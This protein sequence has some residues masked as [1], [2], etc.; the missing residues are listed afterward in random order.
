MARQEKPGRKDEALQVPVVGIGAS[1]GG[2]QSLEAVFDSLPANTGMA[3][4]V[5]QHLSPDFKSL[6]DEILAR[7]TDMPISIAKEDML[8]EADHIYLIPPKK[9]LRIVDY[10]FRLTEFP[11]GIHRPI[12]TFFNS[13][14]ECC[15]SL[16]TGVVLSGT[17]TDGTEGIQTI[18]EVGGLTLGESAESAQF[19]G[20]PRSA[21]AT[22]VLDFVLSANE[23]SALLIKH[24]IEP[25]EKPVKGTQVDTNLDG[26]NLIFSLLSAH[27]NIKFNHYKSKTIARRI[28]RRQNL[29]RCAT[30]FDYAER[31]KQDGEELDNLYHD[32][33]IGVTRF[34]RDTEAFQE[35]EKVVDTQLDG[36]S[37]DETYR[38]W[39]AG[40]ASGEEAY[41]IAM[42]ILDCMKRKGRKPLLKIFATDVHQR[43]LE[44]AARGEYNS[45]S[46]EFVSLER[47]QAYFDQLSDGRF[48]VNSNLRRHLVFACHN[49]IQDPPFTRVHLTT[50][51]NMLIYFRQEAQAISV[52]SFHFALVKGG[53]LF[54]GSSETPGGLADEFA[55]IHRAWRIYSK[56]R[57][58]PGLIA[59]AQLNEPR[60]KSRKPEISLNSDQPAAFS[61]RRLMDIYDTVLKEKISSGFIL[62]HNQDLIHVFGN[63]RKLLQNSA[64][65]FSGN[66]RN[67][68]MGNAKTLI[69]AAL[70]RA[71][72][73]VGTEFFV[74][75][76][77]IDEG[78]SPIVCDVSIQAITG[79]EH[80][81]L[82][83]IIQLTE[84]DD[85]PERK[86]V[87]VFQQDGDVELLES[88]LSFTR[89]SLNATVEELETSNEELQA[90]NEEMVASNEE[91]QSTNEELHSVNE[92]LH[93]VNTEF[94]RK[95]GELE[96]TTNDLENL[97]ST[98][99]IG[100]IFLD[101]DLRI[102]RFTEVITRH[103][104]LMPHDIGRSIKRFASL[105]NYSSLVQDLQE[106]VDSGST[107]ARVTTD[108]LGHSML[109]KMVPYYFA[110][111]I[112]GVILNV[113]SNTS[114]RNIGF[115]IQS[116]AGFWEWPE[117]SGD[118]MLWSS[119]CYKLLGLE[120][121]EIPAA[122]PTW[123]S[124]IHP[125]D[126][127][128]LKDI[129]SEHCSFVKNGF[130]LVRM[131][132][133]NVGYIKFAYRGTFE[134]CPEGKPC[135][136]MGSFSHVDDATIATKGTFEPHITRKIKQLA[137]AS[138]VQNSSPSLTDTTEKPENNE[139]RV[140]KDE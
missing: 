97:L 82:I 120:P 130:L 16:S 61:V 37:V 29:A 105:I 65:R 15:G 85:L 135:S 40:C 53:I 86:K 140:D 17:G 87:K 25:V 77:T 50:C 43:T 18:H 5:I 132:V 127:H 2:L 92:E 71:S 89:E 60:A 74:E 26:I 90:A 100:T 27:Y 79:G 93:S 136:M 122:F 66:I 54:L 32:L 139:E 42:M 4:V 134:L 70:I 64:G 114:Q 7:K 108:D 72:K 123:K 67:F 104:D 116:G 49:V 107:M 103:F 56:V 117:V 6:M 138:E 47:Q 41:S 126:L 121:G 1:A 95:I 129:R 113:V 78:D 110:N 109:L 24:S 75:G 99:D 69:S 23:I 76:L 35:L 58:R 33:L 98:S 119:N 21:A 46:L 13:L 63:A 125:D 51:R 83:W 68:L 96:E 133:K 38:V 34:F 80:E 128:K 102:R 8:I 124:L 12:D 88:E 9:E 118:E 111:Q 115:A 81:N 3:F 19:D 106:V 137:G 39:V 48:R 73:Q 59:T 52:A 31:V 55:I 22:G 45:E 10:H 20:M 84:K 44:F 28:E 11:S 57:N 94:Q 112:T 131:L 101:R 30:I 14:A 36:I 91:L 62:D